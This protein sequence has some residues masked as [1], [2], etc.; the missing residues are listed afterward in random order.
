MN[1]L[2]SLRA[3]SL[4]SR[5]LKVFS[6][7]EVFGGK[8]VAVIGSAASA[9]E[10][11]NGSRINSFDIVVRVNKALFTW[12]PKQEIY[13]GRKTDVLFHSFFENEES[14]GGP[15]DEKAFAEFGMKYLV[16]PLNNRMGLRAQLNFYKRHLRAADTYVL[17]KKKFER[18][19]EEFGNWTPTVGYSAL[20]SVLSSPCAEVFITGFTFFKTPYA[21]GYRDHLL[22]PEANRAHIEHQ[23]LHNPDLEFDLFKKTLSQS[24]CDRV[25]FDS[26]LTSLVNES[27]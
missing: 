11:E 5:K 23:G 18:M 26:T 21:P 9:F 15:I 6:P 16:Q 19:T 20:Y 17:S 14:G 25:T 1:P 3:L 13:V 10:E 22:K 4:M 7:E 8:R 27:T 12:N 2:R 24:H